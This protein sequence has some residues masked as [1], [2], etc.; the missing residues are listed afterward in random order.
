MDFLVSQAAKR[1]LLI[2][3]DM[4]CV[5]AKAGIMD[6]WHLDNEFPEER[7]MQAWSIIVQRHVVSVSSL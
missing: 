6:L 1:G 3:F 4:H 2:M 7:V 5:T